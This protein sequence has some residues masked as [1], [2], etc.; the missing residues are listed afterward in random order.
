M[1]IVQIQC[2][3]KVNLTKY[4]RYALIFVYKMTGME[5]VPRKSYT[6]FYVLYLVLF[7]AFLVTYIRNI[8]RL[9]V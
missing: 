2:V 6:N 4:I 8:T 5:L 3:Q 7:F 9:Y 1:N